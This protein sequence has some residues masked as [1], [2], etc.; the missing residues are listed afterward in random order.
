FE[1]ADHW[2]GSNPW[3]VPFFVVTHH[4]DDGPADAGFTFVDGLGDAIEQARRAAG[5]KDVSVMGG[6][7]IIRQ[8]LR[9][10]Y[11]DELSISIAPVVM[12][13]GKRLFEGFAEPLKLEP[14]RSLQS[15]YATHIT[16]RVVR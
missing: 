15:P 3:P 6:A 11:V 2:G 10:G 16:Y 7:D 12:G 9:A 4:P 13:A 14:V 8:A 1:A 5:E